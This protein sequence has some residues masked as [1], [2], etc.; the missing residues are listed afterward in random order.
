MILPSP[1][2]TNFGLFVLMLVGMGV[3]LYLQ[4][5]AHLE[6]CPLCVFQRVSLMSMGI[7]A[8][9]AFIHNPAA[10]GRRIY[11]GLSLVGALAGVGVAGRHVWLQHLPADE[12]PS[13]GP[14]LDYWMDTFPF[15][16][17][18]Q[19]VLRGSGECAKVDWMMFGL[20]LPEWTLM[21]FVGLTSVVVWQLV[22]KA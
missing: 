12:V 15:Q 20:S 16:E 11:A 5:Y 19:K 7:V 6:P 3:A 1:R 9:I 13:C 17:V 14:G 10:L 8:L 2:L 4:H 21:M 22:R 18:V